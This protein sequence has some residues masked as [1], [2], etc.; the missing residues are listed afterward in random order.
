MKTIFIT[1]GSTGIGAASVAKFAQEAGTVRTPD[2]RMALFRKSSTLKL[3]LTIFTAA[4]SSRW[5][6]N[7]AM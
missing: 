6:E 1:G 7:D 3:S 2:S 4:S 5:G